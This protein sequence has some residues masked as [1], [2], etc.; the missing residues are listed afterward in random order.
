MKLI[1]AL[2]VALSSAA[3]LAQT[4]DG[5]VVGMTMRSDSSAGAFFNVGVSNVRLQRAPHGTPIV[6]FD[7]EGEV[8]LGQPQESRA[9]ASIE[10]LPTERSREIEETKV[11]L[12]AVMFEPSNGPQ[13]AWLGAT[14]LQRNVSKVKFSVALDLGSPLFAP[15]PRQ[16]TVVMPID[17]IGRKGS[18][19]L[20]VRIEGESITTSPIE[21]QWD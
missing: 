21:T 2:V 15:R 4:P 19:V 12:S 16:L 7:V 9:I 1:S 3:A 18:A 11:K 5:E 10:P 6:S 20:R 14:S 13:R 8:G 17:Q